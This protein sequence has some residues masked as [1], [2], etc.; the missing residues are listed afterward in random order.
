MGRTR[1]HSLNDLLEKPARQVKEEKASQWNS[2]SDDVE[3]SWDDDEDEDED[4]DDDSFLDEPWDESDDDDDSS[5]MQPHR[6][7]AAEE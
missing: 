1:R 4:E 7:S 6:R 2:G 3:F 5:W